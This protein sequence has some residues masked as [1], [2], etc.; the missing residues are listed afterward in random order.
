MERGRQRATAL[1][2]QSTAIRAKAHGQIPEAYCSR[3]DQRG[4][5]QFEHAERLSVIVEGRMRRSRP[6]RAYFAMR[7]FFSS[8]S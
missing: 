7:P 3:C 8:S 2:E 6:S 1:I 4:V 5:V